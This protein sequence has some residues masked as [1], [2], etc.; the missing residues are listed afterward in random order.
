MV[1]SISAI[2]NSPYFESPMEAD[3]RTA[4]NCFNPGLKIFSHYFLFSLLL[5]SSFITRSQTTNI[6]GIVNS[7]YRVVDI[8]PAKAAI[9]LANVTGLNMDDKVMIIQMKGASVSTANNSSFGD[10]TSLNNAGNYEIGT[11]C[12]INVD[13]VFL[14]FNLVN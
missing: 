9:K 13:T 3:G 7:Y 2:R 10:T 14:L 8:V 5:F 11:I 1:F 4:A 6:S 12:D